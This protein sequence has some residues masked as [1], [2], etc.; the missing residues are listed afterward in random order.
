VNEPDKASKARLLPPGMR[1]WEFY[2]DG[3]KVWY[4]SQGMIGGWVEPCEVYRLDQVPKIVPPGVCKLRRIPAAF[5][6]N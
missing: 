3:S 6:M 2:P 1:Y 4:D 5:R